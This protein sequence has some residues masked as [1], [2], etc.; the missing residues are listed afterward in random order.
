M[1]RIDFGEVFKVEMF[2]KEVQKP[3]KGP[4]NS[5]NKSNPTVE[6]KIC[7]WNIFEQDS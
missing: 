6:V 3:T 4:A 7:L 2:P 5:S 1:S